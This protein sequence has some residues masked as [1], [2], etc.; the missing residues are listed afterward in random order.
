MFDYMTIRED[1]RLSL[2]LCQINITSE[3]ETGKPKL[4][5]ASYFIRI[6]IEINISDN[7]YVPLHT[8]TKRCNYLPTESSGRSRGV[9]GR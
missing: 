2:D 7:K 4:L 8:Y 1:S 6:L 3:G 5:K 9:C